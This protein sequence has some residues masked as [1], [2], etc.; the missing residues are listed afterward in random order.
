M[1]ISFS[2]YNYTHNV[3]ENNT[4]MMFLIQKYMFINNKNVFF[5]PLDILPKQSFS[6]I[7]EFFAN[8]VNQNKI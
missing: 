8:L 5:P 6:A 7:L 1:N 2:N 3:H 4:N